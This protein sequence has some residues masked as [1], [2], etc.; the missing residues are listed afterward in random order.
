MNKAS[1]SLYYLFAYILCHT[2]CSFQ[3]H[4]NEWIC[5][6]EVGKV[7]V[8]KQRAAFTVERNGTRDLMVVMGMRK[9]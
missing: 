6:G 2:H 4:Y 1:N 9:G 5:D 3:C 8:E 7:V